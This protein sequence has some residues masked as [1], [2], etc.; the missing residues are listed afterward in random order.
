MQTD[1]ISCEQHI[2]TVFV[3]SRFSNNKRTQADLAFFCQFAQVMNQI[4]V[5]S[6]VQVFRCV[7][8]E[9]RKKDS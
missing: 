1:R 6:L 3:P 8:Q 2:K 9:N 5:C 7:L 4:Y